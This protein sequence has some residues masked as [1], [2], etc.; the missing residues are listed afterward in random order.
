MFCIRLYMFYS[1]Y[2]KA[3]GKKTWIT[4][5]EC[6]ICFIYKMIYSYSRYTF[7][8][9]A[10]NGTLCLSAVLLFNFSIEINQ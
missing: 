8:P 1:V 4:V 9:I 3:K 5:L 10:D 6:I 2:R 7:I